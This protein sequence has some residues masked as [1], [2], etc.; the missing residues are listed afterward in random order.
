[1]SHEI[2]L[3]QTAEM[4]HQAEIICA[5]LEAHPDSLEDC[6]VSAISSLLKY[7]TGNVA[8]CLLRETAQ[9]GG[10]NHA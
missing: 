2:T 4:A 5:L 10:A 3:S 6:E 8:A 9:N 7:L 1:M